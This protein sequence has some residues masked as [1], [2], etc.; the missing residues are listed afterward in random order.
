M[1]IRGAPNRNLVLYGLEATGKTAITKALLDALSSQPTSKSVNG[2]AEFSEDELRYAIVKSAECVSGRHLL[3]Q[4]VGAVAKA[5]DWSGNV[6]R[7]ENLAQLVVEI[8]RLLEGWTQLNT[9][10][11]VKQRFVL[12][13]DGIDRQ[14]D[15][16]PTL[17]PSLAK[18]GEIV[19]Y[20][21][22]QI[23]FILMVPDPKHHH[24]L[25]RHRPP[26]QLPPPSGRATYPFP[27]LHQP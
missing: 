1:Q 26:T 5:V 3:E 17:L 13:F 10:G 25:H 15:A 14:R 6:G 8:G 4:T 21:C 2:H 11:R 19:R 22:I 24:N 7:C 23:Q 9:T 27:I 18:L 12:V 20:E 16:T